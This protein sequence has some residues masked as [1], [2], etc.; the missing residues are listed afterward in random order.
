V[1]QRHYDY[2]LIGI[3]E[4]AGNLAGYSVNEASL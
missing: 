1:V 4:V 3:S 2:P